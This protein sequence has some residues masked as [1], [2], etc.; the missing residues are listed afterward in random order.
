MSQNPMEAFIDW[1]NSIPPSHREEIALHMA[2]YFPGF[3]ETPIPQT[4]VDSKFIEYISQNNSSP[5]R[6][7]GI[8]IALHSII[9]FTIMKNH[10]KRELIKDQ[11][12]NLKGLQEFITA[13]RGEEAA[14]FVEKLRIEH[15]FKAAQW[16]NTAESWRAFCENNFTDEVYDC[17]MKG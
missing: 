12:N 9:E 17:L 2:F 8:C 6:V 3:H 14:K 13:K 1:F 5:M 15:P 10:G 4:G 7:I 11:A 16:V